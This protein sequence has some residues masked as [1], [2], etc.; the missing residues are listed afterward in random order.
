MREFAFLV[1]LLMAA[2]CVVVGV[3]SWS[4][5][6]AWIVAG[7][8]LACVGWLALGGDQAASDLGDDE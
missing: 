3:A 8:L 5:G 2:G 6:L 1:I 4:P 7:V